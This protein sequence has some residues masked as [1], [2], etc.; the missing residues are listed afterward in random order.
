MGTRLKCDW[1][2]ALA[3]MGKCLDDQ[4]ELRV[5]NGGVVVPG[6]PT[7]APST[8][9][10]ERKDVDAKATRRSE[11]RPRPRSPRW[12]RTSGRSWTT[13]AAA[14]VVSRHFKKQYEAEL[15]GLGEFYPETQLWYRP[16]GVWLLWKSRVLNELPR[17]ALF[18]TGVSYVSLTVRSWGFWAHELSA[19]LWIGP[20]HTNFGDGSICAF[21][22]MDHTWTF[23][24]PIVRLLDLYT[25][26]ALRHL[27]LEVLGKWP[28]QQVA[29]YRIERI[30]EQ[31]DNEYCGCGASNKLYGDCCKHDDI[32]ETE[33]ADAVQFLFLPRRPPTEVVNALSYGGAPLGIGELVP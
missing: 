33:V 17:H 16:D 5:L 18:L 29:H 13:S 4:A 14:P 28:G 27:H 7:F 12:E 30:L 21:E 32:A 31:R 11:T 6:T 9:G 24:Q 3:D 8:S 26:W 19:P 23:G 20:R 2:R 22:P 25:V 1:T 10:V 15:S